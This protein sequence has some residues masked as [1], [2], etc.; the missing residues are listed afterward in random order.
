M[1]ELGPMT[2]GQVV[3]LCMFF[4][5][6]MFLVKDSTILRKPRE[7]VCRIAFIDA[8]LSCSFCTGVWVGGLWGAW[9]AYY[10]KFSAVDL[11]ELVVVFAMVSATACYII[12]LVTQLIEKRLEDE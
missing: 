9:K 8:L 1:I 6:A 11:I 10:L 12:D 4:Y 2:F 5:G 7:V 3:F